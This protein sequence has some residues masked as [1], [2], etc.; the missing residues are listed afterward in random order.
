[1]RCESLKVLQQKVD[2]N[3]SIPSFG[4][5]FPFAVI[6]FVL[7]IKSSSRLG[8]RCIPHP[9]CSCDVL[10]VFPHSSCNVIKF[11][12]KSQNASILTAC[13]L[14]WSVGTV[15]VAIAHPRQWN[16]LAIVT[17]TREVLRGASFRLC[18]R[19]F[20]CFSDMGEG[21]KSFEFRVC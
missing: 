19:V 7:V 18:I 3:F 6:N 20:F 5:R 4:F 17:P 8:A 12:L 11:P 9:S 16:A 2:R 13:R 21:E 15:L 14:V 10:S 1:M